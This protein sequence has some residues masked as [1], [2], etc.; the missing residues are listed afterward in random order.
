VS[1]QYRVWDELVPPLP[2]W[3][4]RLVC[5]GLGWPTKRMWQ[6]RAERG[7]R[8]EVARRGWALIAGPL[9]TAEMVDGGVLLR[10]SGLASGPADPTVPD[11]PGPADVVDRAEGGAA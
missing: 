1:E 8:R 2:R 5:R 4:W 7:L 10:A 9:V 6:A 3:Y 11:E